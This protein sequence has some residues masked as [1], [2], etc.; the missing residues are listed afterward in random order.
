[1]IAAGG[2]SIST[3]PRRSSHESR[4]ERFVYSTTKA[5]VIGLSKSIAVDYI[6]RDPL[7]RICRA[8]WK[9]PVARR[10]H[11]RTEARS[12]APTVVRLRAAFVR[13]TMG[14]LGRPGKSPRS[15]FT[16]RPPNPPSRPARRRSSTAAGAN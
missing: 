4:A 1:M 13:V 3:C 2:G 14:R 6:A 15:P 16:W 12:Q 11:R 8:R 10:P 5:A 9:T 7:Q